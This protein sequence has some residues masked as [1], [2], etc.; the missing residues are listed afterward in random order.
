MLPKASITLLPEKQQ[1]AW[2]YSREVLTDIALIPDSTAHIHFA[3]ATSGT[4]P[5][6]IRSEC[7]SYLA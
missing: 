2:W 1:Q 7:R 5:S 6:K 3:S 4:E